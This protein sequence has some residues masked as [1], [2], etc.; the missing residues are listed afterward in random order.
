MIVLKRMKHPNILSIEGVAPGLFEFCTVSQWMVHGNIFNYV[1][2]YPD[3]NRLELVGLLRD[4][5]ACVGTH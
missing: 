3:V 5:V 2:I 4:S 1:K